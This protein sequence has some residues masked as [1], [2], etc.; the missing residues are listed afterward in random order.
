MLSFSI[1]SKN[2]LPA[3]AGHRGRCSPVNGVMCGV[4]HPSDPQKVRIFS[5]VP[6]LQETFGPR[7]WT[8]PKMRVSKTHSRITVRE[9]CRSCVNRQGFCRFPLSGSFTVVGR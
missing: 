8:G 6:V 2:Y 9:L 3:D 4:V 1:V 5:C 7:P